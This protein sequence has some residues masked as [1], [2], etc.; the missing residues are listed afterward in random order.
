MTTIER[1]LRGAALSL[2]LLAGASQAQSPQPEAA[3][4]GLPVVDKIWHADY[5]VDAEG[6]VTETV[7]V[8]YQV[9]QEKLLE[10]M[11]VYGISFS[12]SI[13]TGEV[14]EAYTLKK[15]GRQVPVPPGNY[16][17][18]VNNG[19]GS[20]GPMFSDRTQL[21]VVF[22]DFAAGDSVH[23]R[24]RIT[25]KQPMFPGQFSLAM[26]FSPFRAY[27][28][29]RITVHV[30]A[31]LKVGSEAHFLQAAPEALDDAGRRVLEWRY[32]NPKPRRYD[33]DTDNGLW[34]IAE[35]PSVLVSTFPSYE[36]IAA[37]YG[38]R[39]LPKAQPTARIQALARDIVGTETRPREKARLLYEWVSRN[40]TYG[41]NCIGVGAVVPRDTDVVLDNKMGDCKDHATLLQALLAAAGI[42]SEQALVNAGNQ[43]ELAQTPVVS[44]VNHVINYLPDLRLYLDATAKGVPFG[45]M[46]H[47]EYAKPVILIGRTG[48]AVERI[49][50]EPARSNAQKVQMAMKLTPTGGASGTVKIAVQGASAL[51]VRGWFNELTPDRKRD[52]VR[53][54]LKSWGM[55]G[56][57]TIETGNTEGM[58]DSYEFSMRF[59][60]DNYLQRA[61]G[62]LPLAAPINTPFSVMM[63]ADAESRPQ[64]T[65]SSQCHGFRAE[66]TLEYELPP[67]MTLA[68]VPPNL[69]LRQTM[70]DYTATYRQAGRKF[71]VQRVLDDKTATSICSAQV[72]NEFTRQARPVGENVGTQVMYSRR[73]K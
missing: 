45:Y 36:A 62:V 69:R 18:Q 70:V 49:P 66:E 32:A 9:L 16:Q 20:A 51:E 7:T 6:R 65:R 47:G 22:P 35:M 29:V 5:D 26:N 59:E 46:P 34:S 10:G 21:S 43:Y 58:A 15:D 14:L 57:G 48:K 33:A 61:N 72:L 11:K 27:E 25:E 56:T 54:L 60:A 52:F 31:N 12:T 53:D 13:Q 28:D 19:R 24:Y 42:R 73:A 23:V 63:L 8:R 44:M 68:N 40:I 4:D 37:A 55:R 17:T 64:A 38:E 50:D 41:G 67:N 2:A 39:A 3:P 1:A 71:T 30:P